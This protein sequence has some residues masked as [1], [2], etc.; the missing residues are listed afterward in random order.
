M[1]KSNISYEEI[2]LGR[3]VIQN[4]ENKKISNQFFRECD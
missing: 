4:I 2:L 1:K 3:K